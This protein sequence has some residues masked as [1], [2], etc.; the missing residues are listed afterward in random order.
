MSEQTPTQHTAQSIRSRFYS[1]DDAIQVEEMDIF[2]KPD[3]LTITRGLLV[4]EYEIKCS[5]Q[6]LKKELDVIDR[7]REKTA[8]LRPKSWSDWQAGVNYLDSNKEL[9]HYRY[10]V[11]R[12]PGEYAPNF[13]YFILPEDLYNKT[14]E[15]FK[16]LPYGVSSADYFFNLKT[17]RRLHSD[18]TVTE[19]M[20]WQICRNKQM[21]IS[22]LK[23]E[24]ERLN[25]KWA[26]DF[27]NPERVGSGV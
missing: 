17:P 8:L 4:K 10:L 2:F 3:I 9:K 27:R 12:Q 19:Q 25:R 5:Y 26:N 16:G 21:K 24:N 13:F 22:E 6:D 18:V 14:K 23:R 7:V 1:Q 11:E 15:R 20:L